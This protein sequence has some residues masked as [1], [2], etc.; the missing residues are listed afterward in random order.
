MFVKVI[1]PTRK[2]KESNQPGVASIFECETAHFRH[3]EGREATITLDPS[4]VIISLE[5][6]EEGYAD[7]DVYYLNN[8]G[9]TIEKV[10]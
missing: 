8:N 6:N 3:G 5:Y 1:R 4:G 10:A 9:Q 7:A 2:T